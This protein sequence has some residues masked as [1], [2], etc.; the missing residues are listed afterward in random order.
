MIGDLKFHHTSQNSCNWR[1][2]EILWAKKQD[3]VQ[4]SIK[5]IYSGDPL[6]WYSWKWLNSRRVHKR[7]LVH[8][9]NENLRKKSAVKCFFQEIKFRIT[10]SD[11]HLK[12]SHRSPWDFFHNDLALRKWKTHPMSFAAQMINGNNL[13]QSAD[14]ITYSISNWRNY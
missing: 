1:S 10:H 13:I 6:S 11:F 4:L 5:A 3:N 2:K 12:C 14:S 9:F 8:S 7:Q